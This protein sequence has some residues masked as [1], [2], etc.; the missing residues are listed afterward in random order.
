M[1]HEFVCGGLRADS[2][3]GYLKTLGVF[4]AF[5]IQFDPTVRLAFSDDGARFTSDREKEALEGF[6]LDT[7][8]PTPVINPW[9]K[10]GGVAKQSKSPSADALIKQ[11]ESTTSARWR[12]YRESI[13]SARVAVDLSD[14]HGPMKD[15][16]KKKLVVA[17]FRARCPEEAIAW[18]DTAVVLGA[19][20]AGF[21]PIVG[22]G[23]NDGRLDF[24]VTFAGYALSMMDGKAARGVDRGALLRDAIDGTAT[25]TLVP[26]SLGQY[27]PSTAVTFN[28]ANG[29]MAD[30]LVNPWDYIFA[31]E[32]AVTFAG[33]LVKRASSSDRPSYPFS[34]TSVAAGFGSASTGEDTRGELWLPIWAGAASWAAVSALLRRGRLEVDLT[35]NRTT[36]ARSARNSLDAVHGALT[37]GVA[38]GLQR[39]E[40]VVLAARNGLAYTGTNAGVIHVGERRDPAVASLN[41]EILQWIART[42]GLQIGAQALDAIRTYEE[43]VY[44]Y[45]ATRINDHL[46]R[47]RAFQEIIAALGLVDRT[48]ALGPPK[49]HKP[50]PFLESMLLAP[51]GPLDDGSAEHRLARA[52]ASLG[53]WRANNPQSSLRFDLVG[54]RYGSKGLAYGSDRAVLWRSDTKAML[55][56]IAARRT[57]DVAAAR[58][59]ASTKYLLHASAVAMLGD[60]ELLLAEELDLDRLGRLVLG[61]SLIHPA[62][63]P[64]VFEDTA[65]EAGTSADGNESA[66]DE[67][68][69]LGAADHGASGAVER[70]RGKR[71]YDLS[72]SMVDVS[73]IPSGFAILKLAIDRV[74]LPGVNSDPPP[75]DAEIVPLL[76]ANSG[77]RALATA[78]RRLRATGFVPRDVREMLVDDPLLYAAALLVPA[79]RK[80]HHQCIRSA[81][82]ILP[83][84]T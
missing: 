2:F 30:G 43:S 31:L 46:Q 61:Y 26:G 76:L 7:Y 48:V 64:A 5:A 60:F 23:G 12:P 28:L 65:V 32:G 78:E 58:A 66:E 8:A 50:L 81:V 57:R 6:L 38:S 33:A 54:V 24:G 15:A 49:D 21:P 10:G 68:A 69:S 3:L 9:N 29:T 11:I 34:F 52:I 72:R 19:R 56:S 62:A 35:N 36:A 16:E 45:G 84:I 22:S 75:M 51:G 47:A 40:R 53:N 25:A 13:A 39:M 41:R 1:R 18:I 73:E 83:Q 63:R 67:A 82:R 59:D 77:G 27:A 44:A 14:A 80:M 71:T 74:K 37:L 55:A 42:G 20:D 70:S 79:N 4:R 17:L